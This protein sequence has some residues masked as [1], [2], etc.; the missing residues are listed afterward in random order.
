MYRPPGLSGQRQA[1]QSRALIFAAIGRPLRDGV[2]GGRSRPWQPAAAWRVVGL[3]E[4]GY[5]LE[6]KLGCPAAAGSAL[7]RLGVF[8]APM[9]R[10]HGRALWAAPRS[11]PLALDWDEKRRS[12]ALRREEGED[13]FAGDIY[14]ANLSFRAR[15]YIAGDPLAP[16]M[17]GYAATAR[18]PWCG[19]VADGKRQVLSLSPELF[20]ELSVPTVPS[21]PVP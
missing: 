18:A 7:L 1:F 3:G 11:G 15:F 6:A 20:F 9:R 17:S 2:S 4:L 12:A 13:R 21:P 10:G 16:S 5:A 8:D 14:Q 19:F